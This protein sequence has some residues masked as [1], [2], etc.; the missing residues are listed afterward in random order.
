MPPPHN[1]YPDPLFPAPYQTG[2]RIRYSNLG[3]N[4]NGWVRRI[5]NEQDPVS[6]YYNIVDTQEQLGNQNALPYW[7]HYAWVEHLPNGRYVY[8]F[9]HPVPQQAQQQGGKSRRRRSK[10]SKHGT[11]RR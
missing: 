9:P 3:I 2:E 6:R 7:R 4:K 10:R 8:Q 5:K 11:R 1:P